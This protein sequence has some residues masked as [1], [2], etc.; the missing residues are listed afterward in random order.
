MVVVKVAVV[1]VD[2]GAIVVVEQQHDDEQQVSIC[3]C[4]LHS[5]KVEP[6]PTTPIVIVFTS[7]ANAYFDVLVIFW[8]PLF[9]CS[10][11]LLLL[12]LLQQQRKLESSDEL[13]ISEYG[14]QT[15]AIFS[16][17][18]RHGTSSSI[19]SSLSSPS[20]PSS[21]PDIL[22]EEEVNISGTGLPVCGNSKW[23]PVVEATVKPPPPPPP[24]PPPSAELTAKVLP[25]ELPPPLALPP[26]PPPKLKG[27]VVVFVTVVVVVAAGVCV[28]FVDVTAVSFRFG[29]E[30]DII[31]DVGLSD[32]I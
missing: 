31:T 27:I 5:F 23:L 30:S 14:K 18:E 19:S 1:P 3:C 26:L 28:A 17:G 25:I 9:S 32:A 15:Y 10:L 6:T 11:L 12:L 4:W 29:F 21:L 22:N 7:L 20:S 2:A 16:D 24:P 13:I 8:L